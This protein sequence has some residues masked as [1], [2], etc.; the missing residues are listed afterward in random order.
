MDKDNT[1]LYNIMYQ[2][3]KASQLIPALK[4]AGN[5]LPRRF[6]K[7]GETISLDLNDT[8]DTIRVSC[9][10]SYVKTTIVD[11]RISITFEPNTKSSATREARILI[12]RCDASGCHKLL[13][14]LVHQK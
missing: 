2:D 12:Y 5:A 4:Y 11:N 13:Q 1:I 8:V 3:G 7:Y 6:G 9:S 14:F 10:S